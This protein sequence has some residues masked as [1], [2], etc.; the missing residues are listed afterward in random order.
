MTERELIE[1][2]GERV[3]QQACSWAWETA[4]GTGSNRDPGARVAWPPEVADVPHELQELIWL[5]GNASW[6]E[7]VELALALYRQMPTYGTLMYTSHYFREWDDDARALFWSEY[8]ELISDPDDRLADPVGYSLWCDYFEDRETVGEAWL[9][10]AHL[11]G[12]S[13]RGVQR[14]LELSGP[15]PFGLKAPLYDE[16]AFDPLWH[17]FVFRGLLSSGFDYFGD[18]DVKAARRLWPGSLCRRRRPD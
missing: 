9:R 14:L 12:L 2:V 5:G 8:R 18:I 6:I 13:E 4:A 7:R 10:V 16:L 17:V 1:H 15:V 3:F 11:D